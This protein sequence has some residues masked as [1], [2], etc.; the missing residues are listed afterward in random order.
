M[1]V[2]SHV[3]CICIRVAAAAEK[4]VY[5]VVAEPQEPRG[6]PRSRRSMGSRPKAQLTLVPSSRLKASPGAHPTNLN[7]DTNIYIYIYYFCIRFR[8]WL[9]P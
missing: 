7:Y 5:E 2:F 1:H 4:V 9:K 8:N 3:I 6:K